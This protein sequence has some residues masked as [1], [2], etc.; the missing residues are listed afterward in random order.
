MLEYALRLAGSCGSG[1]SAYRHLY[2]GLSN[3]FFMK[4]A[5]MAA[6]ML[7][8]VTPGMVRRVPS[9]LGYPTHTTVV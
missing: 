7:P 8:P 1:K 4:L 9:A 6:G 3:T 2:A 5:Q